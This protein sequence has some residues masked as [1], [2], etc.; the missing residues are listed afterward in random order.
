MLRHLLYKCVAHICIVTFPAT[1]YLFYVLC[2]DKPVV[3]D[4]IDYKYKYRSILSIIIEYAVPLR[5]KFEQH[6]AYNQ[7]KIYVVSVHVHHKWIKLDSIS[8]VDGYIRVEC[9][10]WNGLINPQNYVYISDSTVFTQQ[11]PGDNIWNNEYTNGHVV[12]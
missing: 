8:R 11:A 7:W 2:I 12:R 6:R 9:T 10:Q 1:Y 4:V 5:W 3:S